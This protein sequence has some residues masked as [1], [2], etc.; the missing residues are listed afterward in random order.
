VL[1][2]IDSLTI[3]SLTEA[4]SVLFV[5]HTSHI[6][7]IFLHV[8]VIYFKESRFFNR[9]GLWI[10]LFKFFLH[11]GSNS[12]VILTLFVLYTF[13]HSIWVNL[14]IKRV[15]FGYLLSHATNLIVQL[16]IKNVKLIYFFVYFFRELAIF[17]WSIVN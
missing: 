2:I 11:Q 15:L 6:Q 4:S 9:L 12:R 13:I 14:L 16:S 8:L 17:E 5:D 7:S 1:R 3:R 10:Y